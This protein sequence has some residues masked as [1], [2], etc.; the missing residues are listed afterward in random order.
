MRKR[1]TEFARVFNLDPCNLEGFPKYGKLIDQTI[2]FETILPVR[3]IKRLKES[4][5]PLSNK[6]SAS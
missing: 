3:L 5:Q 2:D 6:I 1:D 4:R